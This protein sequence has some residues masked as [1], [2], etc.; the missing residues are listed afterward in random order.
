MRGLVKGYCEARNP[1]VSSQAVGSRP[2]MSCFRGA[3]LCAAE[4]S[5]SAGACS[6]WRVWEEGFPEVVFQ[7]PVVG[8]CWHN[9]QV[10]VVRQARFVPEL[11]SF[12]DL[13]VFDFQLL[14][15]G[16]PLVRFAQLVGQEE[17]QHTPNHG[18]EQHDG[19]HAAV[20]SQDEAPRFFPSHGLAFVDLSLEQDPTDPRAIR[21]QVHQR[22]QEEQ[23]PPHVPFSHAGIEPHAVVIEPGDATIAC[24]AVFG[25]GRFLPLARAAMP[26]RHVQ[27]SVE[28][29]RSTRLAPRAVHQHAW[30]DEASHD[31]GEEHEGDASRCDP[32]VPGAVDRVPFHQ[33]QRI[34]GGHPRAVEH[35]HQQ[36]EADRQGWIETLAAELQD[37]RRQPQ[38]ERTRPRHPSARGMRRERSRR[39]RANGRSFRR[40]RSVAHRCHSRKDIHARHGCVVDVRAR[41]SRRGVRGGGC[42]RSRVEVWEGVDVE[43]AWKRRRPSHVD[44][45]CIVGVH[46]HPPSSFA[47]ASWIGRTKPSVAESQT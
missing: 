35:A 45:S 18:K 16:L 1:S 5:S 2:T 25:S 17:H 24:T 44:T 22:G 40:R 21:T 29:M 47:N 33:Q 13:F 41:C 38:D 46:L 4:G 10:L 27:Q 20:P 26:S 6:Q 32:T 12:Q 23:E 39:R 43:A 14:F 36:K 42:K 28:G 8:M 11:S 7:T 34:R 37:A 19:G 3:R 15:D 9:E 30:I 31:E